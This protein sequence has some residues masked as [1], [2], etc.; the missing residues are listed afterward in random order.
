MLRK[1]W[2][3]KI[4]KVIMHLTMGKR[5]KI[6]YNVIFVIRKVTEEDIAI[7]LQLG[8]KKILLS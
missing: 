8:W 6:K 7:I 2:V 3:R 5:T 1:A 4:N